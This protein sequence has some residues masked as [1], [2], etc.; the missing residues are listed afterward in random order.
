[1]GTVGRLPKGHD[2]KVFGRRF[3]NPRGI[4]LKGPLWWPSAHVLLST[5]S[6][7]DGVPEAAEVIVATS[8]L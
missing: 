7:D 2:G 6:S 3:K 1:M 8:C 4:R 5:S